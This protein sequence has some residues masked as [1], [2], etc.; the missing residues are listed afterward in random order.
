MWGVCEVGLPD[1]AAAQ[2]PRGVVAR[3][4]GLKVDEAVRVAAH[5][6][7]GVIG[8]LSLEPALFSR[9]PV[10]AACGLLHDLFNVGERRAV[11]K[12][13]GD[14]RVSEHEQLREGVSEFSGGG[15]L[16]NPSIVSVSQEE[17]YLRAELMRILEQRA[18]SRVGKKDQA[19]IGQM[20]GKDV[21]IY[22]GG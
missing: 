13:H 12:A 22:F 18:G 1:P 9:R 4:G 10:T 14:R 7:I 15:H 19:C 11:A 6:A 16:I 5:A 17:F 21:G 8:R 3:S 20:R 2:Q